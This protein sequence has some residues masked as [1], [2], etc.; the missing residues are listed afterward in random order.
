MQGLG[1]ALM[2]LYVGAE[3]AEA[4]C[5]LILENL[6][7]LK[8]RM[9]SHAASMRGFIFGASDAPDAIRWVL[10]IQCP[11]RFEANDAIITG[12]SDW[13]EPADLEADAADD[14]DPAEGASLQ[15]ARL[16]LLLGDQDL[17]KRT[18]TNNTNSLTC[19]EFEI[20]PHGDL[21]IAL[22]GEYALRLFP[23]ASRGEHWR[24]FKKDDASAHLICKA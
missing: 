21:T 7:G 15:E 24:V 9:A 3:R 16:R 19:T 13:Y 18:I 1:I 8:I 17:S 4:T 10:H 2:A 5:R 14:W 23:A 6:V 20:Q 12:S 22:T 11:W